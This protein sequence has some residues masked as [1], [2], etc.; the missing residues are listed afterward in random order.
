VLF[1]DLDGFKAVMT[2]WGIQSA[3]CFWNQL[4]EASRY[5]S[6]NGPY[7]TIAGDEFAILQ[8]SAAQP[9]SSI[10]WQKKS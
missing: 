3:I 4:Q 1:L 7:R 9:G 6:A 5:S 10:A 2:L 8:I